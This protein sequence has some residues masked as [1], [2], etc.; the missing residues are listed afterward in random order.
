MHSPAGQS[1]IRL[2][3]ALAHGDADAAS[4]LLPELDADHRIE[5]LLGAALRDGRGEFAAAK[6]YAEA[7][8][9]SATDPPA[10]HRVCIALATPG[11]TAADDIAAAWV[12][13]G[14]VPDTVRDRG[15]ALTAVERT[16]LADAPE[17]A[18]VACIGAG[19]G[20]EALLAE[21]ADHPLFPAV[22]A[23]YQGGIRAMGWRPLLLLGIVPG[24]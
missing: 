8:G 10:W 5:I 14:R 15:R 2:R 1:A 11:D 7:A 4:V 12:A 9:A 3:R 20:L 22:N 16:S 13:S 21:F 24:R 18:L 6:L 23:Y 19:V 17:A